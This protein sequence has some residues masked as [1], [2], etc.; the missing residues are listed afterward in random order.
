MYIKG[1]S[2]IYY[3]TVYEQPNNELVKGTF[4]SRPSDEY[5]ANFKQAVSFPTEITEKANDSSTATSASYSLNLSN[6]VT[7][8]LKNTADGTEDTTENVASVAD[9]NNLSTGDEYE[10]VSYNQTAYENTVAAL[11]NRMF[12]ALEIQGTNIRNSTVTNML[13]SISQISE[14]LRKTRQAVD[15]LPEKDVSSEAQTAETSENEQLQNTGTAKTGTTVQATPGSQTA[16]QEETKDAQYNENIIDAVTVAPPV[17]S[18]E[19]ANSSQANW[20]LNAMTDATAIK[21]ADNSEKSSDRAHS[22]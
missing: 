20:I 11:D 17:N 8:Y 2:N 21:L 18:G 14:S 19:T 10:S 15:T 3:T 4:Y 7:S 6:A 5:I 22:A 12:Y 13:N 9:S 16:Q 1:P